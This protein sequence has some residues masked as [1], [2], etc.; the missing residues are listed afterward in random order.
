[1]ALLHYFIDVALLAV[2][3]VSL[4]A[5]TIRIHVEDGRSG[6]TISD[7]QVQVWIDNRVGKAL[8][9]IPGR[10]GVTVLEAPAG[11]S[12]YVASNL[13]RDCRPFEKG[14][15]RPTYSVDQIKDEGVVTQNTCGRL[16]SR[17]K[18]GELLFFVRPVRGWEGMK[19]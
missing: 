4:D 17:P 7:E 8:N 6:K 10:D 9:L 18:R 19:R 14:A 5:K 1:M 3:T 12:I 11:S 16:D 2:A 15:K 13:Y